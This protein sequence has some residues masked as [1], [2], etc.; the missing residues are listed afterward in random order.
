MIFEVGDFIAGGDRP[1]I[2]CA[3]VLNVGGNDVQFFEIENPLGQNLT[4][5]PIIEYHKEML[6]ISALQS[7]SLAFATYQLQVTS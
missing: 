3:V 1:L 5:V 7:K 4:D 6:A 2:Q